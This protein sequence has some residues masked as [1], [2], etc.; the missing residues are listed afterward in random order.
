[1]HITDYEYT[2]KEQTLEVS[3]PD[4]LHPMEFSELIRELLTLKK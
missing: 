4:S 3:I 1:V 2:A